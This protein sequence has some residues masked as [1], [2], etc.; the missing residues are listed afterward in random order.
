VKHRRRRAGPPGGRSTF[1]A[2]VRAE[3]RAAADLI[4][5]SPDALTLILARLAMTVTTDPEPTHQCPAGLGAEWLARCPRQVPADKLFCGAHYRLLPGPFRRALNDA[6]DHGRGRGT[7]AHRAAIRA[8]IDQVN[9][10]L[11]EPTHA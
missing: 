4:Q 2:F 8:A 11:E 9:M 7:A 10:R 5:P 1:A 6:W 3:L